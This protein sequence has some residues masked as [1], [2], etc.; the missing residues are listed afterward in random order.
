[1]SN[2][3]EDFDYY[4]TTACST[5]WIPSSSTVSPFVFVFGCPLSFSS[6]APSWVSD[7]DPWPCH[8]AWPHWPGCSYCWLASADTLSAASICLPSRSCC[9][10]AQAGTCLHRWYALHPIES[11]LAVLRRCLNS[12]TAAA[13]T[14]TLHN[15][16]T[17]RAI[18]FLNSNQLS[19]IS[20][21]LSFG[22]VNVQPHLMSSEWCS[23]TDSTFSFN[24]NAY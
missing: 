4:P 19:I 14:G 9:A 23:H 5:D 2:Q 20:L 10:R 15:S 22:T 7:R 18:D 11:L 12:G 16:E 21:D 3:G 8:S 17:L 6:T 13:I 24:F 1:M